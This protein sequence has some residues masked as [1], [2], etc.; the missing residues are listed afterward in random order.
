M[1]T[2]LRKYLWPAYPHL[3]AA[4]LMPAEATHRTSAEQERVVITRWVYG[5]KLKQTEQE[6]LYFS[7]FDVNRKS[8]QECAALY[9]TLLC[10]LYYDNGNPSYFKHL[11]FR[12]Q[13]SEAPKRSSTNRTSTY[14]LKVVLRFN[15]LRMRTEPEPR[16]GQ[17]NPVFFKR[18]Y[19]NCSLSCMT[20][21]LGRT[22]TAEITLVT[23]F[24]QRK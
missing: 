1:R 6:W 19:C 23:R 3:C 12:E 4:P 7:D 24:Y 8:G 22:S 5:W 9:C 10:P 17:K 11:C 18:T 13:G 16:L 2:S 14:S 20:L 21:K 15:L